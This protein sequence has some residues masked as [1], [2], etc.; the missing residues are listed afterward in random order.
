MKKF[1]NPEGHQ[2][3]ISGSKC[4]TILLKGWI[5]P[6]GGDALARVC[7]CSL[8]SRLVFTLV[9]FLQKSNIC[10][11][12]RSQ[13]SLKRT[14]NKKPAECIQTA[15][16]AVYLIKKCLPTIKNCIFFL[17]NNAYSYIKILKPV[18]RP[19]V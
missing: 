13:T 7:A 19:Q 5:L 11:V 12:I 3:R 16:I 18:H 10:H 1:L 17:H 15:V 6:I 8:R 9:R 14:Y 2:N 4:T